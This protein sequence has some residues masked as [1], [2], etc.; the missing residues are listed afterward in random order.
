MK[1]DFIRG[2]NPSCKDKKMKKT[3]Q[4]AQIQAVRI[5]K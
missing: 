5:R 2:T 4:E 3:L 1:K